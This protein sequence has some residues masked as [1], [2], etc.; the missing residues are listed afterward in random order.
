MVSNEFM[1]KATQIS[2]YEHKDG[3]KN[4]YYWHDGSRILPNRLS[5]SDCDLSHVT[6]KGRMCVEKSVGQCLGRFTIV[7]QSPLK[8]VKPFQMR[9]QI[10]K[11]ENFPQFFGYGTCGISDNN[12]KIAD[13]GD[14]II[15]Y[16][17][18]NRRTFK[19]FFMRGMGKDPDLKLEAFMYAEKIIKVM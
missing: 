1:C 11:Y 19:I 10:F 16:S 6:K 9:T 17:D 4:Q 12:G 14:L 5:I 8:R 2:T 3:T 13:T 15:F 7:D 18:D